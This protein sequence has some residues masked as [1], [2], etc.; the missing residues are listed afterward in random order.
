MKMKLAFL[1]A[2][3]VLAISPLSPCKAQ[4]CVGKSLVIG[5]L[6][7]PNLSVMAD[8][9]CTLIT[10][11]TG[12]T[13]VIKGF[14]DYASLSE[15]VKKGEVD[16][17]VDFTGRAYTEVLG[18]APNTDAAKVFAS[19][20]D[21][22]Q[23]E[24]NLVW[25]E[26]LGFSDQSAISAKGGQTPAIAVPVVRK[27]TLNKFPA[28]PRVINKLAGRIDNGLVAKLAAESKGGQGKKVVRKYLKDNRLI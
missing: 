18:M 19:V 24:K 28:L 6:N 16:I 25:L 2:A 12:T 9:L 22:Y 4:A 27:D 13:V 20:K 21:I 7:S 11:R 26:P 3:I 17:M 1:A 15:A 14:D 10:E 5:S 23:R 8:M